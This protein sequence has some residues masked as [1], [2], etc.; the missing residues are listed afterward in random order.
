MAGNVNIVVVPSDKDFNQKLEKAGNKLVIVDFHATWCGPCK[1][2]APVFQQLSIKYPDVVFLKVD[3]DTCTTTAEKYEVTA[4]PTFMAFRSMTKIDICKGANG[5]ELQNMITRCV[6]DNGLSADEGSEVPGHGD[7]SS[8]IHAAGSNCLNE[9]DEHTHA[10]VLQDNDKYI[11]SDCDEQ[12]MLTLSF[13]QAVKV[14]SLK[15]RAPNDGSGPKTIKIFVNQPN[16]V[17]FDQGERM[18]GVQKLVLDEA[19]I[20]GEKL[21]PLRFVKFQNVSNI[22]FFVVD[23]QGGKE[24][25]VINY[26]KLIGCPCNATNMSE[27]KR[28]AGKA[29]ESH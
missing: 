9:S 2:I 17:D 7:M 13:N 14:H 15:I 8:L 28:V 6:G 20:V 21:I 23:N 16:A 18:E 4:M 3:V 19:D 10:N 22:V 24:V 27:F 12:L 25:T 5:K 11:E 29:G 26:I 1:M